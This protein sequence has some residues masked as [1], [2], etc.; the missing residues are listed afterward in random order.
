MVS[1]SELIYHLSQISQQR[2]PNKLGNEV[3]NIKG[4]EAPPYS[5]SPESLTLEEASQARHE[6]TEEF[7]GEVHILRN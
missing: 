3:T 4:T 7:H 2:T 1:Q 6:D 5:L